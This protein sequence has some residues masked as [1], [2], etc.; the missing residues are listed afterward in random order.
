METITKML[1]D[2]GMFDMAIDMIYDQQLDFDVIMS[3]ID[4]LR[5]TLGVQEHTHLLDVVV[6]YLTWGDIQST[7]PDRI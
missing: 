4:G 2:P 1:L 7:S 3:E 6:E 5:P